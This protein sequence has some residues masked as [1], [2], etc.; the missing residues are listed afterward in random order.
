MNYELETIL[1]RGRGLLCGTIPEYNCTICGEQRN[2]YV[3]I[4]SVLAEIQSLISSL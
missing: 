1:G 4:V 2:T 3:G